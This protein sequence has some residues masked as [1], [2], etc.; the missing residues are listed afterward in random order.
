MI[1]KIKII[2][3][4]FLIAG[5]LQLNQANAED[6]KTQEAPAVSG[7][8]SSTFVS[9]NI[10]LNGKPESDYPMQVLSGRIN[11]RSMGLFGGINNDRKEIREINGGLVYQRK[12]AE[13]KIGKFTGKVTLERKAFLDIEKEMYLSDLSLAVNTKLGDLGVIHRERFDSKDY[14]AGRTSV[15]TLTTPAIKLGNIFRMNASL[16]GNVAISYQDKFISTTSEFGYVT[17]GLSLNLKKGNTSIDAFLK[18]QNAM[19]KEL[20]DHTYGGIGITYSFGGK[21]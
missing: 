21:K 8:I 1:D 3:G 20:E 19:R 14:T 13:N 12:L 16:R 15:I 18:N 5:S 7:N 17:P 4:T 11:L 2:L 9:E 6:S 10:L